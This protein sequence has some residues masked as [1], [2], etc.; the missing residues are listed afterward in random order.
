M[1]NLLK[2]QV[3]VDEER[4]VFYATEGVKKREPSALLMG[5]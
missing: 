5:M 3:S 1:S 2:L 4:G